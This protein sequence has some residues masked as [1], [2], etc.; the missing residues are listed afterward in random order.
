MVRHVLP[1]FSSLAVRG[2]NQD[3]PAMKLSSIAA[4]SLFLASSAF[5]AP[6]TLIDFEAPPSFASIDSFY[7][8]LGVVFTGDALALQNDELGPYFS[9]APSPIGVM[10]AAGPDAT[11]NV[12]L[13]FKDEISFSFSSSELV[14]GAVNVYSGLNGT[15]MLLTSLNLEANAQDGCSDSPYCRF[16]RVSSTFGGIAKSV[17]FGASENTAA[18]DDIAITAVPEPGSAL[19]VA[20]GL[21]G[22]LVSRRR[23]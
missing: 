11:M 20:L 1:V 5:A 23:G 18:F 22:L 7:G 9:N 21:A 17:T 13:G 12:A 16:D 3:M 8:S 14:V 6:T 4:C 19:L 10:F 15:G 2:L